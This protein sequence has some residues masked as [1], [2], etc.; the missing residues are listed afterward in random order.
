MIYYIILII[1]TLIGAIASFSLKKASST[2]GLFNMLKHK[3]LYLGG[4]LYLISA[5]LNIYV[6][7]YIDYS[8]V[9]PLTAI[10]YV[11]TMILSRVFLGEKMSMKKATGVCLIAIGAFLLTGNAF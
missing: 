2:D 7:R 10:T 4:G 6:L 9:L 3:P 1:M 11:W 8:I 5:L